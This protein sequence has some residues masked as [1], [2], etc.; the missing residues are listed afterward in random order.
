MKILWIT[1]F[2]FPE[3]ISQITDCGEFNTTGG[4]VLGLADV[5]TEQKDIELSVATVSHLVKSLT[6]INGKNITYYI[7]PLGK[8]N[9]KYNKEYESYWKK[10][11]LYMQPDVVHIHGT[12]Y[13]HGLAFVNACGGEKV[14]VSIQGL[15]SGIAP[16]YCAGLSRKIILRNITFRDL[17]KGGIYRERRRFYKTGKLEIE[18]L[19]KVNHIIGRTSWDMAHVKAINPAATYHFCNE[20][21]RKEFYDGSCWKYTD[22]NKHTIF[23]SQGSSPIKGLHQLI[24]AM[25]LILHYYPDTIIRIAGRNIINNDGL[26]GF[27]HFTGYGKI[28]KKLIKKYHLED[29]LIFLGPLNAN[30]IKDEYLHSNI[31]ICPSSIENSPN[32]L[33]E[34]QILGVPCIASYVGGIPDMMVSNE[35]GMYRFEE[36]EMLANKICNIFASSNHYNNDLTMH[37]AEKRHNATNNIQQLLSIYKQL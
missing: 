22:C 23:L 19:P 32:S 3:A 35:D 15:K 30:Q 12:E 29:K 36:I 31:F 7:I 1:N 37:L 26:Y 25:P 18:I 11:N 33:G 28:I 34:A 5:L 4:W 10:I 6:I 8:G 2:L 24:K 9:I 27:L 21:L 20:I 14:I 16:Y 17:I 13:S